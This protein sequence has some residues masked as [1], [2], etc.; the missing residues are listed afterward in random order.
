MASN[1][2]TALYVGVTNDLERR[3][4]EH[5]TYDL[6]SFTSRYKC[7]KLVYY[8]E[9]SSIEE[10]I[11]REKQIKSWKRVRKERLIGSVNPRWGGI[12]WRVRLPRRFAPRN[13]GKGMLR[14]SQ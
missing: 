10:A 5:R 12:S 14:S 2:N 1:N 9:Y 4:R 13:D 8:E 11:S 3:V 7:H 6:K